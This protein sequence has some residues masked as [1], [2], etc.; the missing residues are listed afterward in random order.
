MSDLSKELREALE[1]EEAGDLDQ[2][3]RRRRP[4][5]FEALRSLLSLNS[6]IPADFRTKAMYALGR[7]GEVS[8]VSDIVRLLPELDEWG[9]ICAVSALGHLRSPEATAAIFEHTDDPS[10]QI[11]KTAALAL[12]RIGTPEASAKLRELAANDP[13]PW[14][15]ELATRKVR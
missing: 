10:P 3:I 5:D 4:D 9:R 12:S 7:W 15:R 8:V 13:L 1:A 11:R 6:S 14:I 2:L